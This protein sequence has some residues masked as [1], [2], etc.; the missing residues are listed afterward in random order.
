[1]ILSYC[2]RFHDCLYQREN[3]KGSIRR[4][5]GR[6]GLPLRGVEG[7]AATPIKAPCGLLSLLSFFFLYLA[8][9]SFFLLYMSI[10]I[11]IYTNIF[12]FLLINLFF[13]LFLFSLPSFFLSLLSFHFNFPFVL[14]T[15]ATF[16]EKK[17]P[18]PKPKK[19]PKI[20]LK[21]AAKRL[22]NFP[23]CGIIFS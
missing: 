20:F 17:R 1:M 8:S 23:H 9:F 11:Y 13:S 22:T 16:S 10:Y 18:P 12:S 19:S 3:P 5:K 21:T 7:S 14:K 4:P 6:S 15:H 2:L